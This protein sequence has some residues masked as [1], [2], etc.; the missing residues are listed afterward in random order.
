MCQVNIFCACVFLLQILYTQVKTLWNI[1][2]LDLKSQSRTLA[3]LTTSTYNILKSFSSTVFPHP[4]LSPL[5]SPQYD[6]VYSFFKN[7]FP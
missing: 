5:S 3:Y 4:H 7:T 6:S 1:T 2:I